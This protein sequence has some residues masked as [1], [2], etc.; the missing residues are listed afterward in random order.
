MRGRRLL[1]VRDASAL[2]DA[3]ASLLVLE[4]VPAALAADILEGY[5]RP[6]FFIGVSTA[7][8]KLFSCVLPACPRA[9]P[10]SE[11]RT[12]SRSWCCT[13]CCANSK[14]IPVERQESVQ[15]SRA[16][17]PLGDAVKTGTATDLPALEAHTEADIDPLGACRA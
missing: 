17:R 9:S 1:L 12:T 6:G 3:G 7:V 15:L 8:V 14:L 4:M 5:F 11:K 13:A 10:R 16:L 2:Q